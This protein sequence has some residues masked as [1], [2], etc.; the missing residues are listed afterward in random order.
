M[1]YHA[2]VTRAAKLLSLLALSAAAIG[3]AAPPAQAA[4]NP[5]AAATMYLVT[6][7]QAVLPGAPPQALRACFEG[8]VAQAAREAAIARGCGLAAQALGHRIVAVDCQVSVISTTVGANGDTAT[9]VA[10]AITM[11][12]WRGTNG[13]TSQ[14]GAGIDHTIT[15]ARRDG[16]WLVSTDTYLD[17]QTPRFLEAAGAAPAVVHDAARRLETAAA[18]GPPRMAPLSFIGQAALAGDPSDGLSVLRRVL[19][20]ATYDR[21]AAK[22]YADKYCLT[23]NPTYMAYSADCA[24]FASQTMFAGKMPQLP[25]DYEN[26]WLYDKHGTSSPS[27]D[28]CSHPWIAVMRQM[29]VW[30]NRFTDARS[31]ISELGKG[32]Y[33]Y[34]DWTGDGVWDH[35]AEVVGTNSSGQYIVDAHTTDY[36]H[37]FWKM[38]SSSTKYRLAHTRATVPLPTP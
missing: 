9:V 17:D 23:Y 5:S 25:G 24:N 7:A 32:D 13:G 22:A 4:D 28:S 3:L 8:S 27:D 1:Q 31:T 19:G 36:F 38:G 34:Y 16:R 33:V 10:H 26:G 14:E 6:R 29:A 30:N 11:I 2:T 18:G 15:L 12:T 21:T 35:V 20:Y 37:T